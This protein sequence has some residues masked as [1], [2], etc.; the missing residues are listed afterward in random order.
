MIS[1]VLVSIYIAVVG[2][3]RSFIRSKT[4]VGLSGGLAAALGFGAGSGL[5]FFLGVPSAA[6]AAAAPF[7]VLGIG[8][9]DALLL[10][11]AYSLTAASAAS[12]SHA[13]SP[14]C[15][16]SRFEGQVS[17][18]A[19]QEE[20][21][22][23]GDCRNK[24][25]NT[26]TIPA[27]EAAA[28]ATAAA[29]MRQTLRDAGIGMTVTTLTNL[30]SFA[31]GAASPYPSIRSFCCFAA[32]GL[33]FGYLNCL[34]LFLGCL[35]IDARNEELRRVPRL[36]Q[37]LPMQELTDSLV[38]R[39]KQ[40]PSRGSAAQNP[41]GDLERG[42]RSP[43]RRRLL[44]REIRTL[45]YVDKTKRVQDSLARLSLQTSSHAAAALPVAEDEAIFHC[46][47]QHV[48]AALLQQEQ[49]RLE[50]EQ[51]RRQR[52]ALKQQKKRKAKQTK[53]TASST[54]AKKRRPAGKKGK[55]ARKKTQD[56]EEDDEESSAPKK[57]TKKT[58]K[59]PK[60]AIAKTRRGKDQSA[61]DS[62]EDVQ[63][64]LSQTREETRPTKTK[65]RRGK[66]T[67]RAFSSAAECR[68]SRSLQSESAAALS[69]SLPTDTEGAALEKP[70]NASSVQ[71]LSVQRLS[72][73]SFPR[74]SE[75]VRV[76][77]VGRIELR[78]LRRTTVRFCKEEDSP[79]VA[80]SL[81]GGGRGSFDGLRS[82][83][84]EGALASGSWSAERIA[85]LQLLRRLQH[86]SA[87]SA[88]L[89]PHGNIGQRMRRILTR[90]GALLLLNPYMKLLLLAVLLGMMG[91]A[92]IG[93][94]KLESGL[95]PKSLTGS[96][97]PLSVGH[98]TRLSA[99]TLA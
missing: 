28:E 45:Q 64:S 31:A 67:Q 65:L 32:A 43:D 98:P 89:E 36:F 83:S 4:L 86:S 60:A 73:A 25:T 62:A 6:A 8:L 27:T 70:R 84:R 74:R 12:R 38:D 66:S 54:G 91:V 22:T 3:S 42:H 81:Q 5:C 33:F 69:Q 99:E 53:K 72:G 35:A 9:D 30:L 80:K 97:A 23:G 58:N 92:V 26:N 79:P 47:T 52:Q 7:L 76:D 16:D 40:R 57:K 71:R 44:L 37:C 1:G 55:G 96:D 21:T 88:S 17:A 29:R 49:Q 75:R 24:V 15:R 82:S 19:A 39:Q 50:A 10:L 95:D 61:S 85:R 2:F 90:V 77:S 13:A 48:E 63:A 20:K 93:C 87:A 18:A 34:T 11:Q 46:I 14:L 68:R 41:L 51:N 56:S 59:K 94:A 78:R